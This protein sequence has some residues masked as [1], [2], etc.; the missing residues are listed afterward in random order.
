MKRDDS[1]QYLP[2]LLQDLWE[3][4]SNP[5]DIVSLLASNIPLSKETQILDL[6]CGKGAVAITITKSLGIKVRGFDL[7]PEFIKY[8]RQKAK[9]YSVDTLCRFETGDINE[10]VTTEKNY[11]CV[12][13]G[14][15]GSILG[16]PQKT[17]EKLKLTIKP[18]GYV[19]IYDVYLLDTA[20]KE[21]VK[22]KEYRYLTYEQW[23][24]MFRQAGMQLVEALPNKRASENASNNKAIIHRAR[25]LTREHPEKKAVFEEF[26]A[27]QLMG[28]YDLEKSVAGTTWLLQAV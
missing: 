1:L 11:D 18:D 28:S 22:L 15:A 21:E 8:A 25:E 26:V 19:L 20:H 24:N 13:L 5:D 23:L 17:L 3:L 16:T 14:S 4:G 10:T 6:A 2:Y 7:M 9:E 12:I 27:M